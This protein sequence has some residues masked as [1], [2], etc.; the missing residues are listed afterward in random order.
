QNGT[1]AGDSLTACSAPG[2]QSVSSGTVI[3]AGRCRFTLGDW[4]AEN[5]GGSDWTAVKLDS[6]GNELWSLQ[7]GG[8][9]DDTVAAVANGEDGSIFLALDVEMSS[10][11]SSGS[12]SNSSTTTTGGA[13]AAFQFEVVKLSG[14]GSELWQWKDDDSNASQL[15]EA[16]A[17]DQQGGV[18]V[19]GLAFD[20]NG[21]DFAAC[22]LDSSGNVTWRW[23]ATTDGLDAVSSIAPANGSFVLGGRT[24]GDFNATSAGGEDFVAVKLDDSGTEV[25]RWQDGTVE[26]DFIEAVAHSDLDGST[27]LAGHTYGSWGS[28]GADGSVS[29]DFAAVKLSSEGQ[30]I[31]RWQDG[32]TDDDTLEGAAIQDDG[33]VVLSGNSGGGFVAL[34]LNASGTEVWRW[35]GGSQE[36]E[37]DSVSLCGSGYD[38]RM[39]LAGLTLASGFGVE[40]E[41]STALGAP[42]FAAVFLNTERS[43]PVD[44]ELASS[45]GSTPVVIAVVAGVLAVAIIGLTVL[46]RW[47]KKHPRRGE[48]SLSPLG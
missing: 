38:G 47:L 46:E 45:A 6:S 19:G 22:K 24:T 44:T 13:S 48:G 21:T 23:Q 20:D 9:G 25:W 33:S 35:E 41:A 37:V 15:A 30:E 39:V 27:V 16:I 5:A 28:G 14:D 10:A 17:V 43:D 7:G 18:L 42:D 12:S 3:L 2:P 36:T 32:T 31:W 4:A 34:R 26:D 29:S 1:A 40:S 8:S 11:A